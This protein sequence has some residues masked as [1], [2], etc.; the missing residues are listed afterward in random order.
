MCWRYQKDK[1]CPHQLLPNSNKQK[2]R[3]IPRGRGLA[4][5][6]KC[7]I[8]HNKTSSWQRPFPFL[9]KQYMLST[10]T[11]QTNRSPP[12][13]PQT[14]KA[15]L[16]TELCNF[17]VLRTK[18]RR[19]LSL[20]FQYLVLQ[21]HICIWHWLELGDRASPLRQ[22]SVLQNNISSWGICNL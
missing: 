7:Q 2:W 10:C 6:T 19:R 11:S 8:Y 14:Q 16:A 17:M 1:S 13:L 12:P 22:N 15:E 5:E 21:K 4:L 20:R 18:T 3:C 9:P